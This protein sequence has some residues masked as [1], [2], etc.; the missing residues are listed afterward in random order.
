[1]SGVSRYAVAIST[2]VATAAS[3]SHLRAMNNLRRVSRTIAYYFLGPR[4]GVPSHLKAEILPQ[5]RAIE[6]RL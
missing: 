2:S 1:M 4:S 6:C 5:N 3:P